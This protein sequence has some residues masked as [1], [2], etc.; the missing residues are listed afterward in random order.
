MAR[1]DFYNIL[2]V[3]R[4]ATPDELKRAFRAL[5]LKYH[6]DRNPDDV[7]APRRFREIVEAYEALSDPEERARY[8]RLG[9]LYRRDGAPPTAEDLSELLSE[10][11][12]GLFGRREQAVRGEDLRYTLSLEL[13]EVAQGVERELVVPRQ[14]GCRRCSGTGAHPDGGSRKCEACEGSGRSPTRRLLRQSCAR[15]DGKGIIITKVC[16]VCSGSCR[17]GTEE[18]LRVKVPPGVAAGQKLK[19]RGKGNE[20][21]GGGDPGDLYVLIQIAEHP[22]FRRRGADVVCE[23]PIRFADAALGTDLRVPTLEGPTTIRVPPATPNGKLLRLSG[24]GLPNPD[25]KGRG[26]LHYRL[27]IEVPTRLGP[28]E[29]ELLERLRQAPDDDSHP[30]RRAFRRAVE[31]S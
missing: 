8:D 13:A 11:F 3:P 15:C 22:L 1:R 29:R 23:V 5:A 16:D 26:D 7:D 18:H 24:R 30:Q 2:G 31:G 9:T 25:G 10:T 21:R 20:G 19:L 6:P 17:H 28:E 12:G 27:S 14:V 4:T